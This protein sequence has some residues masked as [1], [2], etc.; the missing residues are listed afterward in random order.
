FSTAYNLAAD[1]LR[2]REVNM[3]AGTTLMDGKLGLNLIARLDPYAL[4]NANRR[5]DKFNIENGGSLF[6]LTGANFT[7][8]YSF[9][10]TD[11]E[12]KT[13][14]GNN[15]QGQ[16]NGGREDDLFG[17]DMESNRR[18]R[19]REQEE[20]KTSNV[21]DFY[22]LKIPWDLRLAYSVTYSNDR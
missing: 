3:N 6:R 11:F 4:N 1:S 20:D 7:M 8:N 15:E 14:M 19:N 13:S 5:I 21:G 2:W 12:R 22:T 18:N 10:S 9:S 17:S 16:R